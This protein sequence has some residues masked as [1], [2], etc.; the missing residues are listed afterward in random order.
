[1]V[2]YVKTCLVHVVALRRLVLQVLCHHYTPAEALRY[3]D[4][5][6]ER[7]RDPKKSYALEFWTTSQSLIVPRSLTRAVQFKKACD[8]LA[9][10]GWPVF[11]RRTGGG[12][13]PHGVG[14]L[15]VS[16][17]YA[18]DASE[19]PSITG[20]YEMLCSPLLSLMSDFGCRAESG[21]VPGSFCDG[22]YN[23][24]VDG[25]KV[26]GTAQRWTRVRSN[27][28]RQIVFAHAMLLVNA[29]IQSGVRAV[30]K[31]CQACDLENPVFAEKHANINQLVNKTSQSLDQ[32]TIASKLEEAYLFELMSLTE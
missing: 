29:N 18:L 7:F 2:H 9:Q 12:I 8:D 24:V 17:A 6:I 27:V 14:I 10:R 19:Q 32:N 16:L 15:N 5:M 23:I 22:A 13:T 4:A 30:N 20:V 28:S 1:M 21:A 31:L 11:V 25:K 3:E 26:M